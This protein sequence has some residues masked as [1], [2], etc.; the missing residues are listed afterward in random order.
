MIIRQSRTTW[1]SVDRLIERMC[2]VPGQ[3]DIK[4]MV[5]RGLLIRN[6][7]GSKN[8]SDDVVAPS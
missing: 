3:R 6:G 2:A 8:M 1:L 4:D 5:D 7:G